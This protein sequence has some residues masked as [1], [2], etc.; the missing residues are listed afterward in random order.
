[1]RSLSIL[2]PLLLTLFP[3]LGQAA[4]T[5]STSPS[6]AKESAYVEGSVL[7]LDTDEPIKKA[8]VTLQSRTTGGFSVFYVTDEQGHFLFEN[9][10]PGSY[11]LQAS[12]N[13][14]VDAEYGQKKPGAPGAILTL[15]SGQ[16]VTD[17][18]FKLAHTAAISGHVFDE[19]GEPI[20][21]AAVIT[22][23]ASKRQGREQENS[24]EPIL[25]NDLGE[26]RIFG[27]A[28][29]RYYIAVN[30]RREEPFQRN[31]PAPNQK[32]NTGYLPS[33]YPDTSDPAK[34]QAISVG[35][36]DEIRSVDFF[37][38][39][40]HLVTVRG[41][42]INAISGNS[43]GTG[44][45]SLNPQS[46]GLTQALQGLDDNFLLKD[47]SFVLRNVP[48]GSYDLTASYRSSE[49][50]DWHIARRQLE[51]GNSDVEGVTITISRG[52]DI[53]G[54]LMWESVPARD[55]G[56]LRIRLQALGEEQLY[57]AESTVRQD[58]TFHLKNVPEGSYRPVVYLDSR[59]ENFFLKSARYGTATV[60]DA[61][62]TVQI[63][64]DASLELT[65]SSH[66]AQL[67]GVVLD[68]DSVLAAGATV[69]LIPDPPHRGI[70]ELYKS[71]T[72]DQN[73]RF[74]MAGLT[75]GDYE[76][77]GW[78][79]VGESEEEYGAD[80]FDPEWLK[81]YETKGES[82]HLEEADQKSID[83]KLIETRAD[84]AASN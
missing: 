37:L 63:G 50:D 30:Y 22:Y 36:G 79:S 11:D 44:R 70:V 62:F 28:P 24:D 69:V 17:L 34:A 40:T 52:T 29:G 45:I 61:G 1:M 75:P 15:A 41:R 56:D 13:G 82:V 46:P 21:K 71:T 14:Y 53:P 6:A 20:V 83:L 7:R 47:G 19:D 12:R 76:L 74:F 4:Q 42:V 57:F 32:L 25:T 27:L 54:R 39:A 2:C 35:P 49:S 64:A 3:H 60:T 67:S 8:T 51:V 23:R 84:S 48:P 73:G 65:L 72:T 38:R 10:P 9:V 59:E 43:T 68:A 80:W 26:F 81:P 16:R 31:A 5:P 18:I 66:P 58:G 55:P 33:Y 77:F 78:D